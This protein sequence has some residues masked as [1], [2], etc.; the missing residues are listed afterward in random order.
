MVDGNLVLRQDFSSR[1]H[2]L[3]VLGQV[4]HQ[5][6]ITRRWL[7]HHV[8]ICIACG[9]NN[10]LSSRSNTRSKTIS[11]GLRHS[12]NVTLCL[13]LLFSG[14]SSVLETSRR[15]RILRPYWNKSLAGNVPFITLFTV[16]F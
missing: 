15:G 3:F 13:G 16:E 14:L 10:S 4:L 11:S 2:R 6:F 7:H 12:L 9:L 5:C 1:P 8:T